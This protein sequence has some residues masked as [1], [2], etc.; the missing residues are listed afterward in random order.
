MNWIEKLTQRSSVEDTDQVSGLRGEATGF[1]SRWTFAVIKTWIQ[2]WLTKTMV[3]LGN[4]TNDAQVKRTEMGSNNGVATLGSDG[5]VT[6]DQL[7]SAVGVNW[8][9]IG[10]TMSSQSDLQAALNGKAASSHT[11]SI[12]N[13]T[14][15]QAAIDAKADTAHTH[16]LSNITDAGT[17]AALNAP[18]SGNA[19]SGE[20]VKGSDTRLGDSRTPTGGAGGVLS[21]SYPNP[22]FAVDMATQAELN[23]LASTVAGKADS[24]DPRFPSSGQTDA[25]VG[26]TGT[27][28]TSNRFVTEQDGRVNRVLDVVATYNASGCATTTTGGITNGSNVL[29][30]ANASTF[31]V[32]QGILVKGAGA[33]GTHLVTTINLIMGT[34]FTLAS[35]ASTTVSG[36]VVQHDDTAAI[37][38]AVA[39]AFAAA[40]GVVYLTKTGTDDGT[41]VYRCNGPFNATTN[42]IIT[43][44]QTANTSPYGFNITIKIEGECR[45]Y[46]NSAASAVESGTAID[47]TDA[48]TPSSNYPS[49]Y[50]AVIGVGV[51]GAGEW[52]HVFLYVDH[53]LIFVMQNPQFSGIM[54]RK[55]LGLFVGDSVSVHARYVSVSPVEPTG[56]SAAV[57]FP[58]RMNAAWNLIGACYIN[59]F[60]IGVVLSEHMRLQQTM[61]HYCIVGYEIV[62]GG[63]KITGACAAESCKIPISAQ[64]VPDGFVAPLDLMIEIE[65][66]PSAGAPLGANW[67]INTASIWDPDNR[68]R[69]EIRVQ[70]AG[71]GGNL[72]TYPSVNGGKF[73]KIFDLLAT[74]GDETVLGDWRFD[75][76]LNDSSALGF[77][78]TGFNSPTYA[79][80]KVGTHALELNGTNQR[81]EANWMLPNHG[82]PR[83]TIEGWFNLNAL[84][85][86]DG[87]M[88]LCGRW[89]QAD[90]SWMICVNADG[91]VLVKFRSVSQY[92]EQA[93]VDSVSTGSWHKVVV[94]IDGYSGLLRVRVDDGAWATFDS[95]LD[96]DQYRKW[97]L[98]N[99]TADK[100]VFGAANNDYGTSGAPCY[101]LDGLLDHWKIHSRVLTDAEIDAAYEKE[102]V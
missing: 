96:S 57:Y 47:S 89:S 87:L 18:A 75:N 7:P 67:A 21:G 24:T 6:P 29:A 95:K 99:A 72:K 35:N 74:S 97:R 4:V 77:N 53:L 51:G 28:G 90:P 55:A 30:V 81:A 85:V 69:G 3:G 49:S 45:G 33:G 5:K 37:N 54:G 83:M 100:L 76:N 25:M 52:N 71:T 101:F 88:A 23:A 31:K 14:D 43:F 82:L 65:D 42:S 16:T 9:G 46:L 10:G 58:E 98:Y 70:Y 27:P 50:P 32:G 84:P 20:V 60:V 56:Y 61:V 40:G 34:T 38:A 39:D 63:H 59:G 1:E 19:A 62:G 73:V 12:A 102:S 64:Q 66:N 17:A 86:D 92:R 93:A 41:G 94:T 2:S 44:P 48:P 22:G 80:G 79:A 8:G 91:D 13:V 15:L 26:T 68:M 11:H 36:V 78:L